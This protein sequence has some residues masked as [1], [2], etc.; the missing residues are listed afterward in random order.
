M[1]VGIAVGG[2]PASVGLV[3]PGTV[4]A[5]AVRWVTRGWGGGAYG[6]GVA[7]TAAEAVRLAVGKTAD[8]TARDTGPMATTPGSP[9]VGRT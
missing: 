9:T 3:A 8:G 6:W 5:A 4:G 2:A 1:A 7:G